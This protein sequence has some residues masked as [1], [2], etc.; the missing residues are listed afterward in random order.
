MADLTADQV[1]KV[2]VMLRALE[3]A[4]SDTKEMHCKEKE[5]KKVFEKNRKSALDALILAKQRFEQSRRNIYD[6]ETKV[7]MIPFGTQKQSEIEKILK[8]ILPDEPSPCLS[9]FGKASW[10]SIEAEF[11]AAGVECPLALRN[12]H[13]AYYREFSALFNLSKITT[14]TPAAKPD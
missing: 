14:S 11:S 1:G 2:R 12:F 10:S 4:I 3:E 5:N 6:L 7:F 8:K 9:S 13:A